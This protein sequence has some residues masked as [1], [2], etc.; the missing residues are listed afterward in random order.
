MRVLGGNELLPAI[1]S[2]AACY[3]GQVTRD[4][5]YNG[6]PRKEPEAIVC[7][8]APTFT[9]FGNFEILAERQDITHLRQLVDYSIANDLPHLDPTLL[10]NDRKSRTGIFYSLPTLYGLCWKR[11]SHCR[12]DSIVISSP[13]KLPI[14][15]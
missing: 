1:E 8:V 3:G 5:F 6:Q 4:M 11:N 15:P 14:K 7:P 2:Y 9:R 10:A 13:F 12:Q